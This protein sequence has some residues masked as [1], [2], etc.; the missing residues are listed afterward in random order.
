MSNRFKVDKYGR[1]HVYG[2][3]FNQPIP[4]TEIFKIGQESVF[5]VIITLNDR[6]IGNGSAFIYKQLIY[7]NYSYLFFLTNLHVI[8]GIHDAIPILSQDENVNIKLLLR[9]KDKDIEINEVYLTK[10][11]YFDFAGDKT[12]FY[13]QFDFAVFKIRIDT[14]EIFD[15]FSIK[16]E[17][18]FQE[19]DKVYA[20]GYP[21]GLNLS[22]SDG[23]ISHIYNEDEEFLTK[24]NETLAKNFIQH[25]ILINH[26]NS[27]GPTVNE[28]GNIVGISTKG[29]KQQM[30]V[31]INYSL[32][33]YHILKFLGNPEYLEKFRVQEFMN[34][35]K[36]EF[37]KIKS[38][39]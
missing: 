5:P 31:G 4:S 29:I 30:A 32:N 12:G 18:N 22:I 7:D 1:K 13:S 16:E 3:S 34:F 11:I 23:I 37:Q 21:Q 15:F 36:N 20:L 8:Q 10:D 17:R 26:G 14:T 6:S 27:G 24:E 38:L 28:Y 33:I 25:N 2:L 35:I 39:S 9:F 19:G